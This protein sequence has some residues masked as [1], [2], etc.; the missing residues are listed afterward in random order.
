M[1]GWPRI[2]LW[3]WC[4]AFLGGC[5]E[6]DPE[7]S[8]ANLALSPPL[9]RE[10]VTSQEE[11][12]WRDASFATVLKETRGSKAQYADGRLDLVWHVSG[13]GK[14]TWIGD[15]VWVQE[16]TSE[17]VRRD[18]R[19]LVFFAGGLSA[20]IGFINAYPRTIHLLKGIRKEKVFLLVAG[21]NWRAGTELSVVEWVP[22]EGRA[23]V[24]WDVGGE[25]EAG[26]LR[27]RLEE[28][29]SRVVVYGFRPEK[30]ETLRVEASR[31][32]ER[33]GLTIDLYP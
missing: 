23:R 8:A 17:S 31:A 13:F 6:G 33:T 15:G 20:S 1:R 4:V 7:R 18:V 14:R 16:A 28:N 30:L 24:I 21:A 11:R 3:A 29:G 5:T 10:F 25:E 9:P 19:V 22:S 12:E 32:L 26:V 27:F 2:V